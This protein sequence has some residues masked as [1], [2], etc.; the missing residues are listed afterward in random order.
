[1][2]KI[3]VTEALNEL[4]LY[5][6]RITKAIGDANF[7]GAH[8]VADDKVGHTKVTKFVDDA[9]SAWQSINDLMEQRRRIK[10]AV[11][12][13]NACTKVIVNGVEMTVAEA[14]E[15]KTSIV[16]EKQLLT[17]LIEQMESAKTNV[18]KQNLKVEDKIDTLLQAACGTDVKKSDDLYESIAKPYHEKN[19]WEIVDP[20]GAEQISAD[21]SEAISGFLSE[22][23]TVLAV[24]NATTVIEV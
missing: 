10:S 9:K 13:S 8:K 24:S 16:Y 23:D 1:M 7:V 21:L 2:R 17:E 11:V 20:L 15:R 12:K 14:I 3:T 6:A 22:V 18:N 4:K 5:D 19:D